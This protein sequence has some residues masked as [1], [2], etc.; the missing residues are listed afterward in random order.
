LRDDDHPSGVTGA[1]D[2]VADDTPEADFTFLSRLTHEDPATG[3]VNRLLLHDR[4]S[5][6]LLRCR[7]S[8]HR[9]AVVHIDAHSFEAI[10]E[11]HGFDAAAAVLG[12]VVGRL[13]AVIR[14]QDTLSRVG[15]DQFVA[16]L[17]IDRA[18]DLAPVT[19]RLRSVFD[20]PIDVRGTP[21][22]ASAR[23]GTV[24]GAAS[25]T[26]EDLLARADQA[27]SVAEPGKHPAP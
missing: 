10:N 11:E 26:A 4:L 24:L 17:S 13:K 14:A 22:M 27:R 16:V 12:A 19:E 9:V 3:L 25:D 23:L 15:A 8:G 6:A 1:H 2:R 7:R 20:Q 5:Q 21:I 18:Q